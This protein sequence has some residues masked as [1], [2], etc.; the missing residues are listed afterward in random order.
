VISCI[1]PDNIAGL[2]L[3]SSW[4]A[5]RIREI[6]ESRPFDH[7]AVLVRS[8][9][10][11]AVF[12]RAFDDEGIPYAVTGGRGFHDAQEVA[13]LVHLLRVAANP[14]DEI[15]MAAVLR[16]PLAGV[17]DETLLRL[18]QGGNLADALDRLDPASADPFLIR[19]RDELGRWRKVHDPV[20]IVMEAMDACGY[21][22]RL[23]ARERGNVEK[24]LEMLREMA[25]RD[26][27]GEIVDELAAIRDGD[28]REQDS[29][30][31]DPGGCVRVQTIH[32]AKGLEFPVVFIPA[33]Q[34]G[35]REITEPILYSPAMGLGMKWRN[36]VTGDSARDQLFDRILHAHRDR[37]ARESDR[38][39]Y[40][41]MTRAE[42]RLI[43]SCSGVGRLENWAQFLRDRL[44][45]DLLTP[46]GVPRIE[47]G[48][49]FPL[50]VLVTATP[51]V[52]QPPLDRA[53][54]D[55]AAVVVEQPPVEGQ[56]DSI[57]TV[58]AVALFAQCPHRYWLSHAPATPARGWSG[59]GRPEPPE[60]DPLDAS[61]LGTQVHALLA[62][63][64]VENPH[65]EAL[66]LAQRF[67]DSELGRRAA[68]TLLAEREFAFE[69]AIEDVVIRGQI[70]LWFEEGGEVILVDYKTG[71]SE[72]A[73]HAAQVSLYAAAI[74]KYTGHPVDRAFVYQ[75][76]PDV[77]VEVGVE[78][79]NRLILEFREAQERGQFPLREGSHC[80]RCPLYRGECPAW[81]IQ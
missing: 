41:A 5:R 6:A 45:L 19:F 29:D 69:M 44:R 58:S 81:A 20:A 36:P 33:M 9:T 39:L 34:A 4:V 72:P 27:L 22:L 21:E 32:S 26:T 67:H 31:A 64:P 42:E 50:R 53:A 76:R 15:S 77:V 38:L 70:D 47:E 13:D 8:T 16:S 56:Y 17:S 73:M 24:L 10:H 79:V 30:S 80:L 78:P 55:R 49:G 52:S 40:V 61:T 66:A 2:E 14:R 35:T 57:A 23:T 37:E 18:R 1:G 28:P 12:T 11:L 63:S 48:P 74:E 68:R 51:P 54:K 71:E 46:T 59:D 43:L 3:E 25:R 60:A 75:L 62:G 7:I 65:A